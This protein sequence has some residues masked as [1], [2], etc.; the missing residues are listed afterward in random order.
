MN[1]KTRKISNKWACNRKRLK[2]GLMCIVLYPH[3]RY[4]IELQ[5]STTFLKIKR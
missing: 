1:I 3:L 5:M 4:Q 2:L